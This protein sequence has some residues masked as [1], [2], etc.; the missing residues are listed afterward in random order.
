MMPKLGEIK[1]GRD[2]GRKAVTTNHIW[3]ACI[4]CGK[5]RWVVLKKGKPAHLSC[6]CC[7]KGAHGA[8]NQNWKGGRRKNERG[9]ILVYLY[10]DDPFYPM[11]T[12]RPY[13][14][15]HRLVMAKHLGRC[16]EPWEIVHHKNSI[17]DDNRLENLELLPDA[18]KHYSMT[19]L[20]NYIKELEEKVVELTKKLNEEEE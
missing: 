11:A 8:T 3:H 14:M 16:L 6:D 17:R 15:E 12:S 10:E 7:G 5:E 4:A 18:T 1:K 13:V 20:Q 19:V 2:I 9:Y